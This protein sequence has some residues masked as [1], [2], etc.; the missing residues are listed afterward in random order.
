MLT[1]LAHGLCALALVASCKSG[2]PE[3]IAADR[4]CGVAAGMNR[5]ELSRS[6]APRGKGKWQELESTL[7]ETRLRWAGEDGAV[8]QALDIT[9]GTD[10]RARELVFSLRPDDARAAVATMGAPVPSGLSEYAGPDGR[11]VV[12]PG[13]GA[14]TIRLAQAK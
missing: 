10:G 6:F 9:F 4:V 3:R 1:R 2:G 12:A 8:P 7:G 13:L 14:W 11:V 5:K